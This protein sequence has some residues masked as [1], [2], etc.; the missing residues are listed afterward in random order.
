MLHY[1]AHYK[2]HTL[3]LHS[4]HI[5][6]FAS[7]TTTHTTYAQQFYITRNTIYN[8]TLA[9]TQ[10]ALSLTS[11]KYIHLC[12]PLSLHT[13]RAF[14]VTNKSN[15]THH[16]SHR[17]DNIALHITISR[18]YKKKHNT[19]WYAVLHFWNSKALTTKWLMKP[20]CH[21]SLNTSTRRPHTNNY[22]F[23]HKR[24]FHFFF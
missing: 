6:L 17:H 11:A 23:H 1:F 14:Y 15:E 7:H 22:S 10:H 20:F 8:T 18:H 13:K 19:I 2:Q 16:L 4:I 5:T 24:Q 12:T 3:H 21:N 9:H